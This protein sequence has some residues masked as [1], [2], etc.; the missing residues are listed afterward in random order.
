MSVTSTSINW[1]MYQF[2]FYQPGHPWLF[3]S[4]CIKEWRQDSNSNGTEKQ[5]TYYLK[6]H[7]ERIF[8][9]LISSKIITKPLRPSTC[10]F[11]WRKEYWLLKKKRLKGL[12]MWSFVMSANIRKHFRK[13]TKIIQ[14]Y[15]LQ[16]WQNQILE[17]STRKGLA[18]RENWNR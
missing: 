14:R 2:S 6:V 8:I 9:W 10:C 15:Q 11:S 7:N 4:G 1:L 17:I 16:G 12:K 13:N 18:E 5:G 3:V